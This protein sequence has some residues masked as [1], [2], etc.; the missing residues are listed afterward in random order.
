MEKE[1]T[2]RSLTFLVDEAK[3]EAF[4]KELQERLD[5]VEWASRVAVAV[6]ETC[7]K[8]GATVI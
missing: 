1:V 5:K 2:V 4:K 7:R 6:N 3:A 8:Y